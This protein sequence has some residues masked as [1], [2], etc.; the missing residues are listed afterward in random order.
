VGILAAMVGSCLNNA[1][2]RQ[3]ISHRI[4]NRYL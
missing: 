3:V 4:S 1:E 2:I